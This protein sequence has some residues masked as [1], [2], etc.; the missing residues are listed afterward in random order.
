MRAC[1]YIGKNV[2]LKICKLFV[3]FYCGQT[4][5]MNVKEKLLIFPILQLN[6]LFS[7]RGHLF[8]KR[9]QP[10]RR[11]VSDGSISAKLQ[12]YEILYPPFA[13]LSTIQTKKTAQNLA[14]ILPKLGKNLYNYCLHTCTFFPSLLSYPCVLDLSCVARLWLRWMYCIVRFVLYTV[15]FLM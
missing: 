5:L 8:V 12:V 2:Y 3:T 4:I 13:P 11:R 6:V 9:F 14:H 1:L 7:L 15:S 10:C